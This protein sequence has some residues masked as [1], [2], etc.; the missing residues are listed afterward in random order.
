[1]SVETGGVSDGCVGMFVWSSGGVECRATAPAALV[2]SRAGGLRGL[3][4]TKE[5]LYPSSSR[6]SLLLMKWSP[7][8][9]AHFR[10][11]VILRISLSVFV[12]GE[13]VGVVGDGVGEGVV[14]VLGIV[15]LVVATGE[16]LQ[17][18]LMYGFLSNLS[19]T[20]TSWSRDSKTLPLT[21]YKSIIAWYREGSKPILAAWR[22][23]RSLM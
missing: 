17:D 12:V 11:L 21:A 22:T 13:G 19:R 16:A 23:W 20:S 1:M 14:L 4:L 3:G 18:A 8:H 15:I 6:N 7:P 2:G 10:F 9:A 5:I